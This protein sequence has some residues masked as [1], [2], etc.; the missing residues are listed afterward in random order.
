M[1]SDK[2]HPFLNGLS[3][4]RGAPPTVI[5]IFGA[6]GDLTARKLIPAIYNLGVDNLLPSQFFF[7]GVGRKPI[8]N[9]Q[10]QEIARTSVKSFSRRDIVDD[11]WPRIEANIQYHAG[12][13]DDPKSYLDLKEKILKIEESSDRKL[14]LLF[15][16]S[17]PPN[18][19]EPI[20]ENLGASGLANHNANSP[21]ESKVII[22]KPFGK[23]LESAKALNQTITRNF[24]EKQVY[25]IDH[26][27]GKET[28]QDL[29]VQRFSNAIFEPIW[30]RNYVN[31][32]QIT[33]AESL[34][35]GTRGGYYDQSGALR[36]MI[37]NHTMQL[38]ALVAMEPPV[39][40]D[41]ESIRD[42][43][44]KLLK[45]IQPLDLN[46]DNGDVVR[47]QYT[48]GL[49]NGERVPGYMQ[50]E[51]IP[52]TSTTETYAALRLSINNWRW[53]GIPFYMR[54]GKSMSTRV[55]EI[56]IQFKRPPGILFSDDQRFDLAPNTMVLKIQPDEGVTIVMNS[57]VPGLETRTQPVKMDFRYATTFGSNTPEAY[58]RLILDSM[59]GDSTLFIRGDETE[60]SWK[61]ITPILEYWKKC[62]KRGVEEYVAGSWG[63]LAAEQL[64]WANKNEW[65]RSGL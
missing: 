44:V 52:E 1:E 20:L 59:V 46:P 54:S 32:V 62:G 11:V 31:C 22:E 6:S 51:G 58:E 35:V 45:A 26:Y 47:A 39:S 2:R 49:I 64:L 19:F 48:E 18:V 55:S 61:L 3:K 29:L 25:R 30:N 5:V 15:Y 23:D 10:F 9:K 57:K 12:G 14:Q 24:N 41:P 4:H 43:K 38:L 33:V 42:E 60:A 8:E 17:T 56:A 7:I 50:S 37:Q 16:I 34:G 36:D 40:L 28:V 21:I 13:Y 53:K 63:P 65:R 27:L